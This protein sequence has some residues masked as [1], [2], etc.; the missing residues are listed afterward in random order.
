[1][2]TGLTVGELVNEAD[3]GFRLLTKQVGLDQVVEGVHHSDLP[4]P[5]PWM[6][7]RTLLI[8]HGAPFAD[9]AD[10][11]Q[12]LDRISEKSVA[13]V[14]ATGTYVDGLSPDHIEHACRLGM[15]VIEVPQTVAIRTIFSYVY[16]AVAS[17]DMHRLRRA[18]A[19][20]SQ[21]LDLLVEKRGIQE[22]VARLSESLDMGLVLFARDGRVIASCGPRNL[23]DPVLLWRIY[24]DSS[25][26]W[27]PLGIYEAEHGRVQLRRVTVHGRLERVLAAVAMVP[28]DE[29]TDMALSYTQRVIALDL[30]SEREQII[31]RRRVRATLL[32][33]FL[34]REDDAREFVEL[35]RA[36][37]IDIGQS[38]RVM[39]FGSCARNSDQERARRNR[40]RTT[41]V[42]LEMSTALDSAFAEQGIQA[43]SAVDNDS[44]VVLAVLGEIE[45]Q[46]IREAVRRVISSVDESDQAGF[47]VGISSQRT[48]SFC[49][50][51]AFRQAT[52]S[53]HS[54]EQSIS[55]SGG[56]VLF[57]DSSGSYHV[58]EGQ[59]TEALRAMQDRLVTPLEEYDRQHRTALVATLRAFLGNRMSVH[60]TAD[61]LF[62]HRNTLHKRLHRIEE[63]LDVD[64]HSMDDVMELYLALRAADLLKSP[65]AHPSRVA[66]T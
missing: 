37:E 2:D 38:W 65:V 66:L 32:H 18:L 16:H 33:D 8:T 44:I 22:V 28:R 62:V 31:Y 26:S 40:V 47:C 7:D 23:I 5:T 60:E 52:E 21:L 49:P 64:L 51:A 24:L 27:G 11:H 29:L 13:L 10:G 19:V 46:A 6:V 39:A 42:R 17:R 1:M 36:Q 59:S 54:A 63:L 34:S 56:I 12:Y 9:D 3:L 55:A 25:D 20:H 30:V 48:G 57:D 15:P 35:L 58:L 14:L 41:H 45:Q 61:V 50:A 43:I 4:D 53:L